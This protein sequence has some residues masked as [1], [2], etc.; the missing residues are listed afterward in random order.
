MLALSGAFL[1]SDVFWNYYREGFLAI[2]VIIYLVALLLTRPKSKRRP[3]SPAPRGETT[4][5]S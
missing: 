4:L 1:N 5:R 2:L 3:T